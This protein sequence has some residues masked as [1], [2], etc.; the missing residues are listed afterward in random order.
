MP[1]I[2]VIV[3]VYKVE[4]YIRRCVDSLLIQSFSDFELILVDDGSPDHCGLICDEYEEKDKRVHVIHIKNSGVSVARN[5]GIDWVFT[6]SDSH[7]IGF[8]DSD[9]WV[10]PRYL[11]LLL[12]GI[13]R[14]HVNISQC[15]FFWTDS[16]KNVPTVI[17]TMKIITPTEHYAEYYS[18]AVW[19]KLFSRECWEK[20]RFPIGQIYGEDAAIWYKMLLAEHS[21]AL[22]DE[23]LYYYNQRE[24]SVMNNDWSPQ[25]LS[26]M[27]IWDAQI[28]YI[29]KHRNGELIQAA[30]NWYCKIAIHEYN[31]ISR[32]SK[33]TDAEKK[34]YQTVLRRRFRVL[35]FRNRK[36][37]HNSIYYPWFA[38]TAFP[39]SDWC[40]W[41]IRGILGKIVKIHKPV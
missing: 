15:R 7:Y 13:K 37:V 41:T 39:I 4:P 5:T 29:N 8:V 36:Q 19:N 33:L 14:F 34:K 23:K 11:E 25:Y 12:E 28:A 30:V 9:D 18:G 2:S 17:G 6:N 1:Q 21:I 27:D 24:D 31:A 40:Y 10:H 38:Q 26:R 16:P 20:T 35:M 3:P 32:S 22:V